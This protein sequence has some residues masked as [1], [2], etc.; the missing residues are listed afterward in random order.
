MNEQ[1]QNK[2]HTLAHLLA[3]A[4][5]EIY[6]DVKLTLGPAIDDGFY[7]DMEFSSPLSEDTLLEIEKKMKILL[8]TWEQFSHEEKTQEE[9]ER[10]FAGN[11]YKLELIKEIAEKGEKITFYTCGGFTDLC[12]GGHSENPAKDIDPDS[13]KVDRVAGAYWRGDEKNK[14]LTRIYGLAFENKEELE[15]YIWQQEEAKKRD[16]RIIGRQMK[17]Y[18]ISDLVGSGLPLFQKNGQTIR[19]ELTEYLWS[20][21]KN[22]GYEWVWTPHLAK[23]VLYETSG[24]AG[25]YMEDMFS[26]WGGTSKEK[27]YV[28]PMNCPHH[29]QLFADNSFS[30]KQ[31]PVRYFEPATVYRDEKTGQLAGL[32]RVRAIT[33]DDG[34][35][36]VRV[37]QIE[38]EVKTMVDIVKEFYG[39][40]GMLASYKVRLSLRDDD[41]L[42]WLG[43]DEVWE[44]AQTA[45]TNVCKN[46]NL[47]YFEGPGEAAF[48]GPK[49]DFIFNDAIGREWQLA[50]IQCDFN[51]P[52]RFKL[53]FVNE[54][55]K[56][57]QPVV[58]HRAISGSLERFIG[59]AIE[60]FAGNFPTWLSPIQ[61]AVVPVRADQHRD[62]AHELTAKLREK[63]IRV[64][65]YESEN[66]LGKRI[67]EAKSM[68][69]PYVIVLGDKEVASG[70]LTIEK[71]D[72]TKEEISVD[73]FIE[74]LEKEVKEKT[75]N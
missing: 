25:Q 46:N 69:T 22:R 18:T 67:H 60:N 41:K 62:K 68:K 23:E 9:A 1:L 24:H 53:S 37:N 74:R 64:E 29:M 8:P 4:V 36:F 7:Y 55:G 75:L 5:L 71:R 16:H 20:L 63:D 72:G 42:K 11:P 38:E 54:E 51:Q 40:M 52:N 19:R 47:P 48:Y 13:F 30:Y 14:M 26:V 39:T 12:R 17:I 50:T 45:L 15:K 6:P 56:E 57:E 44:K 21:H 59:V 2:R 73:A 27:F 35:I 3:A 10:Y 32:T 66:S 70:N 49:L 33:Q 28:K 61:V 31:L 65:L 58:I 34:H 43:T